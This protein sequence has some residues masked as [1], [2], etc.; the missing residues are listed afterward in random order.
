MDIR[1][2]KN[3]LY[4][5]CLNI[6]TSKVFTRFINLTILINT[7]VLAFDHHPMDPNLE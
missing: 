5:L 4:R 1:A 7:F 3:R 6:I 2:D